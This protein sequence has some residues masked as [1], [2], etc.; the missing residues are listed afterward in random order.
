MIYYECIV[1][2]QVIGVKV[3][4]INKPA[5]AKKKVAFALTAAA[6]GKRERYVVGS[7]ETLLRFKP[8]V[9]ALK[10]VLAL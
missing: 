7:G 3:V 9:A 5:R 4:G 1:T 10:E 6:P 8:W 2:A